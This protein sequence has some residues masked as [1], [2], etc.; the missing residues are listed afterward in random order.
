MP[1]RH[2]APTSSG[3]VDDRQPI[4]GNGFYL[5]E[6]GKLPVVWSPA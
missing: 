5:L 1:Q 4:V 6:Q 2:R 3:G